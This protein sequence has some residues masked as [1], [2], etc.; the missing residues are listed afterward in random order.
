MH[1]AGDSQHLLTM[2]I[3]VSSDKFLFVNEL[4]GEFVRVVLTNFHLV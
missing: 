1:S 2:E 4:S 3:V